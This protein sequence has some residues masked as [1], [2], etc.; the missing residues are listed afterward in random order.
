MQ[1]K[2]ACATWSLGQERRSGLTGRKKSCARH[3]PLIPEV[4][5]R[6]TPQAGLLAHRACG[7]VWRIYLKSSRSRRIDA[8]CRAP[9]LRRRSSR[10]QHSDLPLHR[11]AALHSAYS[12]GYSPR[13]DGFRDGVRH[14]SDI[15]RTG[16]PFSSRAPNHADAARTS[17]ACERTLLTY[18]APRSEPTPSHSP[19]IFCAYAF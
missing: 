10:A 14:W 4:C 13:V 9:R 1:T 5:W 6:I 11:S 2:D 16:V 3:H 12:C 8:S 19:F 17:G 7:Y 18:A 15:R